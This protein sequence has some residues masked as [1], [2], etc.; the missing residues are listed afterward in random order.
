VQSQ[1][2]PRL[3]AYLLLKDQNSYQ[4]AE[5][6]KY[7]AEKLPDYMVPGIYILLDQIVLTSNSKIDKSKLPNPEL[8]HVNGNQS[9]RPPKNDIETRILN[10]WKEVLNREQI[11]TEETFFEMGGHSLLLLKAH[12]KLEAVF[13]R[14]IPIV[15]IFQHPT[16]KSFAAYLSAKSKTSVIA[17]STQD[18]AQKQRLAFQ[19][20][21]EL[22][23]QRKK[24]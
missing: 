18:N 7:L 11:S 3:A 22:M 12:V 5:M 13:Q 4:Q 19:K 8:A 10:I 15:E 24:S 21:R 6:K 23:A 20:Q 1:T 17:P 16:I 9:I 14:E 2:N